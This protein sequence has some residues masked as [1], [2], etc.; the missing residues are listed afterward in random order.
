MCSC[1]CVHVFFMYV[2]AP[3]CVFVC[4]NVCM[5]SCVFMCVCPCV[6]MRE[7]IVCAPNLTVECAFMF[8]SVG[9]LNTTSNE[10]KVC[11][12]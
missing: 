11:M 1:V 12:Y 5:C 7:C 10:S 3:M 2:F 8:C 6:C 9:A 4:V